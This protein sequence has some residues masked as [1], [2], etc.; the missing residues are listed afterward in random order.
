MAIVAAFQ[1]VFAGVRYATGPDDQHLPLR[2]L[3]IA[4]NLACVA[5]T[6]GP[7]AERR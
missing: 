7:W 6:Y 4:V 1:V 5:F 3:I 2:F